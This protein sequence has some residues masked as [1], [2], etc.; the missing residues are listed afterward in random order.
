MPRGSSAAGVSN[1]PADEAECIIP[2]I[3]DWLELDASDDWV[4]HD[5]EIVSEPRSVAP[6]LPPS[7]RPP[8]PRPGYC[9]PPQLERARADAPLPCAG[10]PARGRVRVVSERAVRGPPAAEQPDAGRGVRARGE[11]RAR[12]GAV[13]GVLRARADLRRGHG[14]AGAVALAVARAVARRPAEHVPVL[15]LVRRP[16]A[17]GR[18]RAA[19]VEH[20][21]VGDVGHDPDDLRV[22][23]APD[24]E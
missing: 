10:P 22:Q 15:G 21:D 20:D 13:H 14:R 6:F 8:A 23:P 2:L 7:S 19:R 5:A 1:C 4:R 18:R 17:R 12:L 3:S 16:R 9:A 11:R 24:A